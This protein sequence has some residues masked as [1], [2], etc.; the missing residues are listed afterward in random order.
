MLVIAL[1]LVPHRMSA[2]AADKSKLSRLAQ[3]R[4]GRLSSCE[5]LLVQAAAQG[6]HADCRSGDTSENDTAKSDQWRPERTVRAGLISWFCTDKTAREQTHHRGLRLLGARVHERIML[7]FATC[8]FL[9]ALHDSAIRDG[10]DFS[11]A[12]IRMISLSGSRLGPINGLGAHVEG[13]VFF[14]KIRVTGE[15]SLAGAQLDSRIECDGSWFMNPGGR[16]LLANSL[17][18]KG[19][20]FLRDGFRADGEVNLIGAWIGEDLDFSGARLANP[21]GAALNADAI[22]VKG[23]VFLTGGFRAKGTVRFTNAQVGSALAGDGAWLMDPAGTA[24]LASGIEVRAVFLRDGF[25]AKGEV[26]LVAARIGS[27]LEC[28]GA[29]IVNPRRRALS[30]DGMDVKGGVFLRHGFRAN[31]NVSFWGA[32]VGTLQ[33]LRAHSKEMTLDLR[34]LRVGVLLDDE[35][36]W[37]SQNRLLLDGFAFDNLAEMSPSD[38]E[39]RLGWLRLQP[40]VYPQ[41]YEQLA[42][43]LRKQGHVDDADRILLE[44]EREIAKRSSLVWLALGWIVG[45]GYAPLRAAW[46]SFGIVVFGTLAFKR[47]AASGLMIASKEGRDVTRLNPFI[48]SIDLFTPLVNLYQADDFRPDPKRGRVLW[49]GIRTGAVLRWY[50]WFQIAAGWVLSTLTAIGLSGLVRG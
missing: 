38:A 30:T 41:P 2:G 18:A 14:T 15:V 33:V 35:V 9:V 21:G 6:G 34:N 42:A 40:D 36:S 29:R 39:T 20:V 11:H 10:L 19:G 37:P 32:H 48:Y 31:G 46:V 12:H 17:N 25:R 49:R 7:D 16:A 5:Q 27:T 22:G 1:V 8:P 3:D 45:Y 26:N 13:P 28:D 50:F 4:F 24:L 47:A 44:K 43:A 23:T